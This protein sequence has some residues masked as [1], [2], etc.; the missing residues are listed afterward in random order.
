M[1]LATP[2][3][4]SALLADQPR[5]AIAASSAAGTAGNRSPSGPKASRTFPPDPASSGSSA[6]TGTL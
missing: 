5:R 4:T 2:S 1:T 3:C 6:P